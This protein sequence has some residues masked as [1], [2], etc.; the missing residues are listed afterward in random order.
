LRDIAKKVKVK[1]TDKGKPLPVEFATWNK[2]IEG[3]RSRISAARAKPKSA[4]QNEQLQFYSDAAEQCGYIRDLWR[5]DVSHHRK[6]FND[7][8]AL[9]VMTRVQQFM[10]L[11]AKRQP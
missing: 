7:G 4:R 8:E 6:S 3:I 1:L 5:N 10:E 2:V 9:G 11:L